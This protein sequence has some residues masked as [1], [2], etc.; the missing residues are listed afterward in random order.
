MDHG[1]GREIKVIADLE[2][3]SQRVAGE[4]ARLIEEGLRERGRV[5]LALAG[6]HTPR[7]LYQILAETYRKIPWERIHLFWSDERCVP[8]DHR[9]SNFAMAKETLLSKIQ[10]PPENVHRIPAELEPPERAARAYEQ[11]LR[12]F[13]DCEDRTFDLILLGVG[14]DG[15]T[16]SLFPCTAA[17][18]EETRWVRAVTAPPSYAIRQRI[19]L[20]LPVLNKACSAF[21]LIHGAEKREIAQA[22]L[23][24]P[25]AAAK[26]YPAAI[27]RPQE[28]LIWFLDE[29]ADG[30]E[31]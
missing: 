17:L 2:T 3:L 14:P 7:R 9:E 28:H 25:Q 10:I 22:I 24:D 1:I 15:H 21:F 27:V 23:S 29:A 12:D 20:T 26:R 13:F 31:R 16:A 6:G 18:R 4:V 5:A 19:T 11:T 8:S 30:E